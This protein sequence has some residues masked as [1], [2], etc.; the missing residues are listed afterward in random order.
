M[1]QSSNRD[2]VY[3]NTQII[4]FYLHADKPVCCENRVKES[5]GVSLFL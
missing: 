4:P 1:G 2:T 3:K 5:Q